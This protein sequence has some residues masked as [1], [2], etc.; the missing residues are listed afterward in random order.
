MDGED[1]LVLIVR[2]FG[3]G[4]AQLAWAGGFVDKGET[5]TDAA[6]REKDEETEVSLSGDDSS[7]RFD[8]TTTEL[9]PVRMMDWD[10]RAKLVEGMEVAA[11]VTHYRFHC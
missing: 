2:Q 4:R 10:P 11:V 5:F 7:V 9:K 6:L 1:W 8:I 3:P